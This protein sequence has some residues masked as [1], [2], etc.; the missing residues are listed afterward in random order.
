MCHRDDSI[1]HQQRACYIARA[2]VAS[3]ASGRESIRCGSSSGRGSQVAPPQPT[4]GDSVIIGASDLAQM[5]GLGET[6]RSNKSS[7]EVT[8]GRARQNS[9][10]VRAVRA[11]LVNFGR[12]KHGCVPRRVKPGRGRGGANDVHAR[13]SVA[14]RGLPGARAAASARAC[15]PLVR[16]GHPIP[17]AYA[18]RPRSLRVA[19]PMMLR[20]AR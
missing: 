5:N 2:A 8:K 17:H 19:G 13:G 7:V 1:R 18:D 16:P 14:H 10:K 15:D 12:R 20:W 4:F 6:I 3:C 9:P 11:R